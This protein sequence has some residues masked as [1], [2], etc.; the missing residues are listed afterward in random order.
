MNPTSVCL[1]CRRLLRTGAVLALSA[2]ALAAGPAAAQQ[3]PDKPIK[4]V[5]PFPPG[6]AT[7][8]IGRV[9]AQRLSTALGQSA[10]VY[11]RGGAS[12]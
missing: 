7:D 6:G 11:N 4:L 9:M 3:Y 8:V 2:L 5:V 12:G 1:S 10:V